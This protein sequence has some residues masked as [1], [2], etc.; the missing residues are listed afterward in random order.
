VKPTVL[1]VM[2]SE[3]FYRVNQNRIFKSVIKKNVYDATQVCSTS[4]VMTQEIWGLFGER[5]DVEVT[6][7]GIDIEK[8]QLSGKEDQNLSCDFVVG[9]VKWLESKYAVDILIKAFAIFCNKYP[10]KKFRL[11][12]VGGGSKEAEL[13]ELAK[14]L[15]V[16]G[17]CEFVG[18]VSHE[19]V[20]KWLSKLDVYVAVSRF[21]SESFG[22]AVLEASATGLPVIVSDAG[23]LPEVVEHGETGIVVPKE[24]V[25]ATAEALIKLYEDQ[26]FAATLGENGRKRV[27]EKYDWNQSVD[28]MEEVYRKV[29]HNHS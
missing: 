4:E 26:H 12:L 15:R 9:T 27:Q 13:K 10:E 28:I 21:D 6:P 7:F 24:N 1:S 5:L 19:N 25:E 20:P 14:D 23:G 3:V 29:T 2:G 8:F 17:Y 18:D 16:Y 11:I 22:V